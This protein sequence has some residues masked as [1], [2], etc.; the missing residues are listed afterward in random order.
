MINKNI[1]AGNFTRDPELRQTQGG[2]SICNFSI[3]NNESWTDGNGNK[4]EYVSY[5]ECVAF[6]KTAETIQKYFSKGKPI[7]IEAKAKQDR[8]QDDNAKNHSKIVFRVEKFHFIGC[9]ES[10]QNQPQDWPDEEP[11]PF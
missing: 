3:A 7:L 8:W 5:F 1:I 11:Q 6:G 2:S 10:T 4:Q 9:K